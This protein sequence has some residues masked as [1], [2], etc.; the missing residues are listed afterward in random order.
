MKE[1]IIEWQRLVV[2][3]ETCPRCG[4]TEQEIEQAIKKLAEDGLSVALI[5]KELSK[6]EFDQLPQESN[7][8]LINGRTIE[9]W[10]T[11]KTGKSC[12]C[13]ACGDAECRT[14]EY[15]D[16]VYETIPAELII[17]AAL[18]AAQEG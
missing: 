7:R 5:K 3:N 14:I 17:K 1:L 18:V 8:L 9:S 10:L 6:A 15:A 12:C 11:A 2:D 16:R 4:S 13:D